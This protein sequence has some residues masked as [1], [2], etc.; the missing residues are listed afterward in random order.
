MS[1]E[2]FLDQLDFFRRQILRKPPIVIDF[3]N[4]MKNFTPLV[5][6]KLWQFVDDLRFAHGQILRF[7]KSPRKLVL[8]H[9][10]ISR[11]HRAIAR[12]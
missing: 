9:L 5:R 8:G 4:S 6:R 2:T 7:R 3:L 10:V 1:R 11:Q 12:R